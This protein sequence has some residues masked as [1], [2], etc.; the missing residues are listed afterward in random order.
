MIFPEPT[1]ISWYP[2]ISSTSQRHFQGSSCG[3]GTKV[4][5]TYAWD[6]M[7]RR[8]HKRHRLQV[9]NLT[10]S[11]TGLQWFPDGHGF[12]QWTGNNSKALM[13]VFIPAIE[14]HIPQDIV[15]MFCALLEFCYITQHN[16]IT[17]ASLVQLSDVLTM[18]HCYPQV[19]KTTGTVPHFLLSHQHS[20]THYADMIQLFGASNRLCSLITESKHIKVVKEPWRWS[21]K[22][23]AL[24]QMLLTNQWLDKLAASR[25]CRDSILYRLVLAYFMAHNNWASQHNITIMCRVIPHIMCSFPAIMHQTHDTFPHSRNAFPCSCIFTFYCTS[26]CFSRIFMFHCAS[27]HSIAI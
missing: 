7:R 26:S 8:D 23:N 14:G 15:H 9:H 25:Q 22:H 5:Q 19:F 18:F 11:F 24:G 20:M 1:F 3:L 4:S 21:N 17:E 12:K 2:L 13:K 27:L 16:V 6:Q 10:H